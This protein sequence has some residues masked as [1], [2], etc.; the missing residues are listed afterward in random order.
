[1]LHVMRSIKHQN[2]QNE[3]LMIISIWNQ[4]NLFP[5]ISLF[6]LE[7]VLRQQKFSEKLFPWH[8]PL[9]KVVDVKR[10]P[11]LF[12]KLSLLKVWSN[13]RS[14]TARHFRQLMLRGMCVRVWKIKNSS[15]I[16]HYANNIFQSAFNMYKVVLT[17]KIRSD[18][19]C[20]ENKI[21]ITK[22]VTAPFYKINISIVSSRTPVR[23]SNSIN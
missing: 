8:S 11:G 2:P 3:K 9:S 20:L 1:M 22:N 4:I 15:E 19:V 13:L 10:G 16:F 23:V 14:R 12:Q 18:Y 21:K 6:P 5:C 17:I 7:N